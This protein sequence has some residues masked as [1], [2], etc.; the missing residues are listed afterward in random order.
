MLNFDAGEIL[1][2]RGLLDQEQLNELRAQALGGRELFSTA[3]D[4]GLV[5]EEAALRAVGDVLGMEFVDLRNADVDLNVVKNF[6]Q[7]LI[8]RHSLFPLS[9]VNGSLTLA[10]SDPLDVYALDEASAATG[11]SI[12]PVVSEKAEIARLMKK[13]LGVG[14]ETVEGLM[15]AREDDEI[16]LLE[17]IESDGSELG[18]MAQQASVVRLV[19]EILVE[20]VDSRASDVH[21]ES[22]STGIVVRYRIDGI[23]HDQPVPPEINRFQ[24]AIISR[25]KIMARLNIAE[26]RLPQ[27][28]RIKLKVH[29]REID[30]RLSAIPMIHGESLVMRILDK[31]SMKFDLQGLGMDPHTYGIFSQLIRLPHGIVLVTGPTG[32]GKT[33]TLYSSLLEIR[34][35]EN[36]IITTEDPVEYQLDGINQIQVHSKIGLTFAASLRSILRHDPDIVLVGEIRDAETAENAIQASLTGHLVFSTLHTNDAAG[37]FTRIVDMGIE[38]FLVS[39]TVE[40]IMAQRLLRKLCPACKVPYT[41][42]NEDIPSDFPWEKLAGQ[43]LYRNVGCRNC[44]NVGYAGRMGIYELLVTNEEIKTLA[45]DRVSTWEIKQAALKAGMRTLRMDAWDKA[46][47]G[48]TSVEEVIRVTKGDRLS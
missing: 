29:G 4:R 41:P 43:P 17:D 31:G 40:G 32:S 3:I 7:K 33:T 42:A 46:I 23:L 11:L 6:P 5:E 38:P 47:E 37:A 14:S 12:V 30:I 21:I 22:Q 28:G 15:A 8:Y 35:P 24:A 18:E 10:T 13:H 16:Q 39:S 34:S 2:Q 26:K 19:N 45:H 27:D 9:R 25:L 20:A 36:K 48:R 44:R 1:L